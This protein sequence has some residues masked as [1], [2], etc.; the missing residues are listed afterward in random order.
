ML[1]LLRHCGDKQEHAAKEMNDRLA[2]EFELTEEELRA[3]LPSGQQRVLD[4]RVAWA[5]SYLKMAKL[6]DSPRR[7]YVKITERGEGVIGKPPQRI[8]I[9]FLEQF[10]ELNE[11]RFAKKPPKEKAEG[12]SEVNGTETP[13]EALEHSYQGMRQRLIDELLASI[14]SSSP[15]FFEQLV[16]EL[17][18]KMGYGGSRLDA[19]KAIGGSGDEG[20]DGFIKED[21]LGLDIIY[22]Q[23][24]KW[25]NTVGR[26]EI[27]KF[28]GALQGQRARKGLFITTSDFSTEA[29]D[30]V[31]RI[32][33]KI[34]LINGRDLAAFMVDHNVG[35][36]VIASYDVKKID[37]DY[38]TEE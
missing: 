1:P 12:D 23:A 5:K 18:V 9:K 33:N 19:G 32:E 29:K 7:G 27:Q 35:V 10:P 11:A 17:I 26:P 36:S 8:T 20:I 3:V 14:R 21:K 34:V 6:L 15:K 2:K 30:Y 25:E 13:E 24:K 31:S 28:A 16:V 22:L 4:N 37:T 38:F